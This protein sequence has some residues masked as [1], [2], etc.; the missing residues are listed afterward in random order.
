MYRAKTTGAAT[1]HSGDVAD[2]VVRHQKST[3]RAAQP[4]RA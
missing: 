2:T 1:C 4:V 3:R